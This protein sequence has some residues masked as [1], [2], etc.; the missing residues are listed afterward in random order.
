MALLMLSLSLALFSAPASAAGPSL[1]IT[2][3]SD[4]LVTRT[5]TIS[6]TGTTDGT[7]VT[8]N[9]AKASLIADNF[10]HQVQL[11]EGPNTILVVAEDASGNTTTR[12][13]SVVLDTV[14]PAFS[15]MGPVLVPPNG[16]VPTLETNLTMVDV[17]GVVEKGTTI[18]A[19]GVQATIT[20][21][22]YLAQV[23][24]DANVTSIVV[25]ATDPAGNTASTTVPVIFDDQI[26]LNATLVDEYWDKE[27]KRYLTYYDRTEVKGTTDPGNNV[28]INGIPVELE[29]DG[30]FKTE[31][32]LD[33]GREF[34][35]I[36]ARDRA[37]NNMTVQY[38]IERLEWTPFVVPVEL[39]VILLI[40]GLV[41][42]SY[43]GMVLGRHRERKAQQ[44]KRMEAL[45]KAG[46]APPTRKDIARAQTDERR[47]R[48]EME[49]GKAPPPKKT[50]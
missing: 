35:V 47:R 38:E 16:P 14:L 25:T 3:P 36:E 4:G 11:A 17:T 2:A 1:D 15:V 40:I 19:N 31:V 5:S 18:S 28:T 24:L 39:A 13:V 22:G 21:Y 48:K 26:D 27:E 32:L 6:V 33:V 7:N 43:G 23:P 50:G 49:K 41:L 42:G 30:S 12:A 45:R 29:D 20:G 37:G 44:K 34:I 9:G 10:T 46:K 8:V